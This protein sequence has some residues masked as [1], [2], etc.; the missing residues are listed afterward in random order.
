MS[1]FKQVCSR[2]R[3]PVL[4]FCVHLPC[5]ILICSCATPPCW[6]PPNAS[7]RKVIILPRR[8]RHTDQRVGCP[9]ISQQLLAKA[10]FSL[11]CRAHLF[12]QD[13]QLVQQQLPTTYVSWPATPRGLPV[14]PLPLLSYL[15]CL[16]GCSATVMLWNLLSGRVSHWLT[17]ILPLW[18]FTGQHS[19]MFLHPAPDRATGWYWTSPP[20][21]SKKGL[22]LF[23][24]ILLLKIAVRII[25]F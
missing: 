14:F 10:S 6:Y 11:N 2:V 9:W 20:Q 8:G 7:D 19:V 22:Q 13:D 21:H 15:V 24:K 25:I 16:V 4:Q 17:R 5:I 18:N 23:V 3:M 12:T 1:L